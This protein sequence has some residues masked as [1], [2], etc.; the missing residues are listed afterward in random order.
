MAD[1]MTRDPKGKAKRKLRSA[2]S[3]A[4]M[5]ALE[6]EVENLKNTTTS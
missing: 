4:R 1:S 6:Q 2:A 5:A 3:L